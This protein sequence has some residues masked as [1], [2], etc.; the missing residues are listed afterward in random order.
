MDDDRAAHVLEALLNA[1]VVI[2]DEGPAS[3]REALADV[4]A[5]AEGDPYAA[6]AVAAALVPVDKPLDRWWQHLRSVPMIEPLPTPDIDEVAIERRMY[7]ERVPLSGAEL[8]E[9]VRR[10]TRGGYSSQ[11]IGE[12][13]HV[14]A[15]TVERHKRR[16]V[17]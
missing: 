6:L 16:E 15:R 1:A 12:R 7:G 3:V 10:L 14:S 13:L 4:L 5:A 9:A 11:M 8:T 17:A 2:R